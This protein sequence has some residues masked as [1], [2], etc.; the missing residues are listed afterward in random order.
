MRI[1]NRSLIIMFSRGLTQATTIILGVVLV[2]LVSK[3]VFGTYRQGL[4]VYHLVVGLLSLNLDLSLYYFVPKFGAG[5]RGT[6]LLQT[7]MASLVLSAAMAVFM[8]VAA[9]PIARMFGNPALPPLIRILSLYP[10]VERLIILVPAFMI[11]LDRPLRAGL[12]TLAASG[13][14]IAVVVAVFALSDS[15]PAVMLSMVLVTAV[16]AA[17]GWADMAR[18]APRETW[19]L[20]RS[21]ILEQ[22]SYCWPLWASAV[23]TVVNLEL[24]KFIISVFFAPADYAVYSCGAVDLP[25]VTLVTMSVSAAIMP[26]LVTLVSQD[27]TRQ[28]LRIW[29]EAT[30]KCSLVI[31]PCFAF[32]LVVSQDL[33]VFVYGQA[34]ALAAAPF[35][36]YLLRLPVRVAVYGSL[37]RAVGRT[38]PVAIGAVVALV[39]NVPLSLGLTYLGGG[40]HLSF[41]GPSIGSVCASFAAMFYLQLNLRRV[42][43]V[44]FSRLMRW[45]ELGSTLLLSVVCGAIVFLAALALPDMPLA[46]KLALQGAA[47][48]GLVILIMLR[49]GM[50][51]DDE[52]ELLAIPLRAARRLLTGGRAG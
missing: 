1:R 9:E 48:A 16:V 23:V 32:C 27:N 38:A 34:Y 52:R 50:L 28:A 36:I 39:V 44:P 49:T 30:R 35:A 40:G 12:Y 29:Q 13:G 31:L 11:S 4:L 6:L 18:L 33:I 3:E 22:L 15:L 5:R 17:V 20:D 46:I 45:K 42:L 10:F 26:N 19:A 21:L 51:H 37:L 7:S 2:R 24:G 41:I 8:L 25:V 47:F 14:R 43:D